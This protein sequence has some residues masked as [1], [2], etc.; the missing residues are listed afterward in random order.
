[1]LSQSLS[2]FVPSDHGIPFRAHFF[3]PSALQY[4]C[5]QKKMSEV[6]KKLSRL[7]G[8]VSM[9]RSR[10]D[11]CWLD[12]MVPTSPETA[13]NGDSLKEK[14]TQRFQRTK[15]EPKKESNTIPTHDDPPILA[16]D[17]MQLPEPL[18]Q[19]ACQTIVDCLKG[20]SR[21]I[22]HRERVPM[23][24]L[25]NL[26]NEIVR[27]PLNRQRAVHTPSMH[28][29]E[30]PRNCPS[31]EN[32]TERVFEYTTKD[33]CVIVVP[34]HRR[35]V[36]LH[37]RLNKKQHETADNFCMSSRRITCVRPNPPSIKKGLACATSSSRLPHR[38]SVLPN[39]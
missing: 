7:D 38:V 8:T 12:E 15:C 31:S 9:G 17:A 29:A 13:L 22:E 16:P 6:K 36:P 39:I 20:D 28:S 25:N 1:M 26:V 30:T 2:H 10:S 11:S 3:R 19:S 37:R 33:P 4:T 27:S 14:C 35:L 18:F 24:R 34:F 5:L 32:T 21:T 23:Q